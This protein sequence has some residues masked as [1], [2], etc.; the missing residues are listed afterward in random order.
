MFAPETSEHTDLNE[1]VKPNSVARALDRPLTW[2]KGKTELGSRRS[3]TCEVVC[4]T[5]AEN[6]FCDSRSNVENQ[7]VVFDSG[8][9]TGLLSQPAIVFVYLRE[10][11]SE[12]GTAIAA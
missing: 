8:L 10:T 7:T 1:R 6:S 11:L 5:F 12:A 2:K 9:E 4:W 3:K